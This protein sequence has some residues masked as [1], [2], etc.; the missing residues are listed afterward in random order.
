MEQIVRDARIAQIYEG[1]NGVQAL[2]LVGRKVMR[3]GGATVRLLVDE[4]AKSDVAD[5]HQTD[6]NTALDR[7]VRVTSS[8]VQR[9][10]NDPN[11]PGAVSTD[12]LELI[13]LTIYA[14]LWACMSHAAPDDEF[15]AGK[16]M[17]ANFFFD[18]LL[19][20]TIGLEQSI[21]SSSE[22]LMEPGVD[23]F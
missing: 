18:R 5:R 22:S 9:S 23:Y 21:L 2:D 4:M 13:G 3:D 11:L 19:P 14:W 6:L 8:V 20:R 12:Y 16:Q 15:G 17:T 7:L 1:T 10:Q